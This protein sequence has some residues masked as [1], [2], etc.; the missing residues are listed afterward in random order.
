MCAAGGCR[1]RNCRGSEC[2]AR[3][4]SKI[5]C[6]RSVRGAKPHQPSFD[7][8]PI[9]NPQ[10][11]LAALQE[12]VRQA[13]AGHQTLAIRGGGSK[14]WLGTKPAGA[15]TLDIRPYSGIVSYEPTELVIT[16][17]AGTPLAEL[18]AALAAQGQCL[19]FDPPHFAQT[20]AKATVG[21]MVAAGLAGP[22]RLGAGGVRDYVLGAVLLNGKGEVLHFGGQVMKNVAGFDVSRLLVGSMGSLGAI[23]EVSLKVLP[24]AP[25]EATL[26]FEMGKE[27]ALEQIN[28][29]GGQPLPIAASAWWR[30]GAG[31]DRLHVR[32]RGAQ[33]AVR[34]AVARLGGERL[35]EPAA[36]ALW[37]GLR[38][39]SLP[40]FEPTWAQPGASGEPLWRLAVPSTSPPL[41][42]QG[43]ILVEWGGAQR[44]MKT[45]MPAAVIREA[46]AQVGGHATRF[47][48]GEPGASVFTPPPAALE[49]IHR[50]VKRAFDPHDIFA[51][52]F[53][54]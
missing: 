22:G 19:P 49:R 23:L 26:M 42:L 54:A 39:Q 31:N 13:V 20:G 51:G 53:G 12:Q 2:G 29:W 52:V 37:Q 4:L 45:V 38:E 9:V 24:H 28:T 6:T 41:K 7:P 17:R 47:R 50:E 21:G 16:A 36:A 46:A 48:G 15:Q 5:P 3:L 27:H 35:Q 30:D 1:S 33:A 8:E 11:H 14:C 25:S 10:D 18:E 34:A 44:W 43:D 40:W 32:L